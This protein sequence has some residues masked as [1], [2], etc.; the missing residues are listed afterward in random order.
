M[1]QQALSYRN[2][3]A[4][5][6]SVVATIEPVYKVREPVSAVVMHIL[7]V[8]A[9][10]K[11]RAEEGNHCESHCIGSEEREH[12]RERQRREQK[13]TDSVEKD[14]RKEDDGGGEGGGKHRKRH[15]AAAFLCGLF[16]WLAHLEM[17]KDVFQNHD[18]VI[19]EA[20]KGQ[21]QAAKHH[22]VDRLSKDIENKKR[23]QRGERNRE[24][25]SH[26]CPPAAQKDKNHQRGKHQAD[27][28]F[29]A[30]VRDGCLHEDRL[31][32]DHPAHQC[33]R[34]VQ[35]MFE[36]LANS[37]HHGNRIASAAL[38]EDGQIDRFLTVDAHDVGLNCGIALCLADV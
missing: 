17:A 16:G 25:D 13:A 34:H 12:H 29:A 3:V 20:G 27:A 37:I 6:H 21:R 9:A 15:L 11:A 26:G 19:D 5:Q 4:H 2:V 36:G 8:R 18:R 28:A 32:E 33:F 14:H 31:I 1:L 7:Q 22:G 23:R 10:K 35:Q 38:L 30:Q 24:H